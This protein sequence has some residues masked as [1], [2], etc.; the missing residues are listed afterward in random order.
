MEKIEFIRDSLRRYYDS[1]T[2]PAPPS[3]ERREFGAGNDKKIDW[4]HLSFPAEQQLNAYLR[5]DTPLYISYSAGYYEF[6]EGRPMAKKNWLGADLVF[7][8]DADEYEMDC[9]HAKDLV[10]DKCMNRVKEECIKL[11]EEFL[12]PDFGFAKDDLHIIFSGNRGYHIHIRR[13]DVHSLSQNAR[14]EILDFITASGLKPALHI[15]RQGKHLVGPRTDAW[16]W[17]GRI[18]R[19]I[20]DEINTGNEKSVARRLGMSPATAKKILSKKELVLGGIAVGDWDQVNLDPKTWRRA[21]GLLAIEMNAEVDKGVT[22][23]VSRLMR[24]PNSIHGGTGFVACEVPN[25]DKFNYYSDPVVLGDDEVRCIARAT[26]DVVLKDKVFE[27]EEEKQLS[28]PEYAAFYCA[29]KGLV[30]IWG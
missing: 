27:L 10:C 15:R 17:P 13:E 7:D 29:A 8:L 1:H 22:M 19:A 4:R 21:F 25:L 12:V 26:T 2:V 28:L 11:I 16:G 20:T 18:S 23:D 14:K 24:L 6:P 30:S 9:K 3:I 5:A